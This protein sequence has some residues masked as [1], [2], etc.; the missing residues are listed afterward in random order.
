MYS[1]CWYHAAAVDIIA[2]MLYLL[3]L[4]LYFV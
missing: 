2:Y 3:M 1:S 4:N